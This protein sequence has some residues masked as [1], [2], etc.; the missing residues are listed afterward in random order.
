MLDRYEEYQEECDKLKSAACSKS[1]KKRPL[2]RNKLDDEPDSKSKR[3][4]SDE[5]CDD[6]NCGS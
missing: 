6:E 3:R 5:L 1:G 4:C 2:V